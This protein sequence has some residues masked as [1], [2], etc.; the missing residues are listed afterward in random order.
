M[1][2]ESP[3]HLVLSRLRDEIRRIERRPA[4]RSGSLAC[5]QEEIDRQLPG[6]GFP[7]GA[8]TEVCGGPASGKTRVALAVL[9]ALEDHALAAFVD[10]R[11]E[12]YPPALR[13]LG[14]DLARLLIVRPVPRQARDERRGE[15]DPMFA[16]LWAAEALLGSGAFDAVAIDVPLVR[17]PRGLD[18]AL[19][20]VQ[21]AAEKGGA[22]GVWLSGPDAR[23]RAPAVARVDLDRVERSAASPRAT[24]ARAGHAA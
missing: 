7:R 22:V 11:G 10:G 19:R 14:V 13:A 21:A 9:R 2:A 17:A 23:V 15:P 24:R 8:I 6:G 20:R 1:P 4:R 5:G 3:R 16:G 18:P 12:L